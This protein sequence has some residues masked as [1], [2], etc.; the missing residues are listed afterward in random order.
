M[1]E[2][3]RYQALLAPWKCSVPAE[4]IRGSLGPIL[5]AAVFG[6]RCF[7]QTPVLEVEGVEGEI[8]ENVVNHLSLGGK[9]CDTPSWQLERL[10]KRADDEIRRALKVFGY[11]HATSEKAFTTGENCWQARFTVV[12]GPRVI[13]SKLDVRILGEAAGD[14]AFIKVRQKF[15][16]YEGEPLHH[17]RYEEAKRMLQS[18]ATERG[19]FDA[20]FTARQLRVDT[21]ADSAEIILH[22]ESGPRYRFGELRLNQEALSPEFV[23]SYVEIEDDEPYSGGKLAA[24]N[25]ALTNSGYFSAVDIR[26]RI[27]SADNFR[28]PVDVKLTPRKRHYWSLGVGFDTDTGPRGTA[29]YENRRVNQEGHRFSVNLKVSP[30]LSDVGTEYKIPLDNPA[31][32]YFSLRAG[33]KREKTDSIDSISMVVGGRWAVLRESGWLE[34]RS[35]DLLRE[36]F[37][38]GGDSGSATLLVPGISWSRSRSDNPLRIRDG[39]RV[40][41]EIRGGYD[42]LLSDTSFFQGKAYGKKI[43]SLPWEGRII[44]RAELGATAVDDFSKLPA[45]Y[46]F[47][48]GGDQSVRGYAYKQLGPRDNNGDTRGGRFLSVFSLEYDHPIL[49]NWRIAAFVDTGNATDR[50]GVNLKTGV[51]GGIRWQTPIGLLRLDIAFPLNEAEDDFR[52]HFAMGPEL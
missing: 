50:F 34:T 11:Y 25:R 45:S 30:V 35:L 17:G 27:Q 14:E 19:Y 41:F 16:L 4:F 43:A 23:G 8:R 21:K 12:P 13:V 18:L 24:L 38:T 22:F 46:R 20:R 29:G 26:P 36:D 51:G 28:V 1:I 32:D 44:G 6:G 37:D 40:N 31:K 5:A 15:P 7:A 48:A 2:I 3:F 52:I 10:F 47:Y 42:A 39:Y 9:S 49:E 33:F